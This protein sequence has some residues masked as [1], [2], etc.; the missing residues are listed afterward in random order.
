VPEKKKYYEMI[1]LT[2]SLNL[3]YFLT[4]KGHAYILDQTIEMIA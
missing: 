3:K 1:C 2:Q 4:V